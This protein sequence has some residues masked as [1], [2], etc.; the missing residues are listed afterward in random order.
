MTQRKEKFII[1]RILIYS[2]ICIHFIIFDPQFFFGGRYLQKLVIFC[3][4]WYLSAVPWV[5]RNSN[6]SLSSL[7]FS[8]ASRYL[9]YAKSQQFSKSGPTLLGSVTQK[10]RTL[11]IWSSLLLPSPGRSQELGISSKLQGSVREWRGQPCN[12]KRGPHIFLL[13]L[14]QLVLHSPEV[15]E[16]FNWFLYF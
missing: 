11:D 1:R 12:G 10:V 16:P 4:L 14:M 5:L 13:A 7:L 15:Q 6:M 9:E 3:S 8:V 2:S